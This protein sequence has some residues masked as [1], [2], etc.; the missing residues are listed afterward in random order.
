VAAGTT[1][2]VIPLIAV[3]KIAA[4]PTTLVSKFD[5]FGS[6][7]SS[8]SCAFLFLLGLAFWGAVAVITDIVFF[9][10]ILYLHT[11]SKK[12]YIF[13]KILALSTLKHKLSLVLS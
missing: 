1:P 9:L 11:Q 6:F 8:G 4:S 5:S 12:K 3:V 10:H 7:G 2:E 13:S